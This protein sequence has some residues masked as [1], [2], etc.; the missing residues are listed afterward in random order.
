MRF[1]V[2]LARRAVLYCAVCSCRFEFLDRRDDEGVANDLFGG[3]VA[4]PTV[5]AE[6]I[7]QQAER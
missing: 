3:A 7:D 2:L 1:G 4:G 6:P 5:K